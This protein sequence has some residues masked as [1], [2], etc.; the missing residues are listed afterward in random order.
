[1]GLFGEKVSKEE[2]QNEKLQKFMQ[3]YHL[4]DIEVEDFPLVQEIASDL[5]GNGLA[6]VSVTFGGKVE[7]MAK[8]TYLSALVRQNWIIINQLTRIEKELKKK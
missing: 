1:M 4:D 3:R 2:K 8:L 6:T 7:D 5:S